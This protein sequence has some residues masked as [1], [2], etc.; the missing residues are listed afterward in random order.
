MARA[1]LG[2]LLS[3][4]SDVAETQ[5][6]PPEPPPAQSDPPGA[7][8]SAPAPTRGARK[9]ATPAQPAASKASADTTATS[10]HYTDFERIEARL[11]DDQVNDLDVLVRRLNKQRAGQGERITRNTLLRVASDLLLAMDERVVGATEDAIR[12]SVTA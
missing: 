6:A 10:T 2:S 12:K 3:V 5:D 7:P 4:A 1:N 11:R 9:R 8:L